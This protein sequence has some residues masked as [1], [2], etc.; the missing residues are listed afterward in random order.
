MPN[1]EDRL[2]G[3]TIKAI[4]PLTKEELAAHAWYGSPGVVI[5]LDDGTKLLPVRDEEG[6][7]VGAL[8]VEE[9]DRTVLLSWHPMR[10][11]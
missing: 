1:F 4:R 8:M 10:R 6:N 2:I 11:P 9:A 5:V 7:D 3:R